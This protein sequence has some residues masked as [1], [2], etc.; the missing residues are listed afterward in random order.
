VAPE[1]GVTAMTFAEMRKG[2]VVARI[3]T[4]TGVPERHYGPGNNYVWV[5]DV[6]GSLRAVIIPED[7]ATPTFETGFLIV[8]ENL[9]LGRRPAEAKFRWNSETKQEDVWV[10]CDIGCCLISGCVRQ[11]CRN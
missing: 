4:L 9:G 1:I 2:R 6:K 3:T 11:P 5:D 7:P 8:H 10:Q